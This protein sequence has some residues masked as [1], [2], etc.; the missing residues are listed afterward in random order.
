MSI[1]SL[2]FFVFVA[3]AALIYYIVPIR[4]RWLAILFA[5]AYFIVTANSV[6]IAIIWFAGG[7]VTYFTA[8][9]SDSLK[10][11]E[12][13]GTKAVTYLGVFIIFMCLI[14][15][16]GSFFSFA[17]KL[18]GIFGAE[19]LEGVN[20][21]APIGISYYSL[22]WIGYMLDVY[23]GTCE[24]EKN[25]FKFMAFMG[26]FPTLTSGPIVRA[27]NLNNMII[28][29]NRFSY[30]NLTYGIQR[31]LWGMM[32]KLVI[33]ERLA[34][35][36]NA[37]YDNPYEYSGTYIWLA[38]FIF[39]F[40]LYTDFS[41]CID[42]V[43]GTS[44]IFGIMLPENFNLPFMALSL[45]EFWRNWHIT[46]GEWL[47]EYIFYPLL[48][49]GLFQKL[50]EKSKKVFGKKT[51]KKIPVWIGL[52][53]SWIV[54]GFWH[55]TSLNYVFGV[56]FFFGFI[57]I[58]E[59][60]LSPLKKK[61]TDFLHINTETLSYRMFQRI[62]TFVFFMIGNSFFRSY[63]GLKAGFNLWKQAFVYNPWVLFDGSLLR[64]GLTYNDYGV[65][66]FFMTIVIVVGVIRYYAKE[67][68]RDLIAKQ[69]LPFR[70]ILFILL[71][72]AVVVYGCY[73]I[74]FESKNFIY[75]GF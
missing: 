47:K 27:Q 5:N 62:K 42:I 35:F 73:G 34:I 50:A 2:S 3:I 59:Q 46:L 58:L 61:V 55:G 9:L 31:I 11:K 24:V 36:V 7:L 16:K 15:L 37:V 30:K 52:M 28:P 23:W 10:K 17:Y 68:I 60:M 39:V 54:I 71:F 18:A 20:L 65:I 32:K 8:L 48:K 51:G 29:G 22:V 64:L 33:S 41:G 38:M 21:I 49:S 70:W 56:G 12:K 69:N 44:E 72:V 67:Q 75:Q 53:I 40:Q 45:E 13:K 74:D 26:Y 1:T 6:P 25:P 43:L 4:F 19:N 14:V 66:F 63:L 57:I